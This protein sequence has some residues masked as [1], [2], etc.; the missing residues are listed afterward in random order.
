MCIMARH[1][2]QSRPA[3]LRSM[4]G[5]KRRLGG[6]TEG[7]GDRIHREI[8]RGAVGPQRTI[9][10]GAT[11]IVK[12]IVNVRSC[13]TC[14]S[15]PMPMPM[16][17]RLSALGDALTDG[18]SLLV[19]YGAGQHGA[20]WPHRPHQNTII[21]FVWRPGPTTTTGPYNFVNERMVSYGGTS[22]RACGVFDPT[23][24]DPHCALRLYSTPRQPLFCC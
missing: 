11:N 4:T 1:G 17:L 9:Y 10:Y 13:A 16:T 19:A 12:R 5:Q 21:T 22:A 6:N 23:I 7:G 8:E 24:P 15:R 18:S 2:Q 14:F 3:M 20:A